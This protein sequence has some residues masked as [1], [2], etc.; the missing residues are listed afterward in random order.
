V[1]ND[2]ESIDDIGREYISREESKSQYTDKKH[3][4]CDN[5]C[6]RDRE[7]EVARDIAESVAED[8][9]DEQL[10]VSS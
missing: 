3:Q 10:A 4:K 7:S 9:H 8:M 6:S 2:P 5:K 1:D